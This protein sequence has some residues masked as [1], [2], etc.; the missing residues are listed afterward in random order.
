MP[1]QRRAT[2]ARHDRHLE[3]AEAKLALAY[4]LVPLFLTRTIRIRLKNVHRPT[5]DQLLEV[6]LGVGVLAAPLAVVATGL[7]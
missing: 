1:C 3:P 2:G 5:R 7:W 6:P 4:V